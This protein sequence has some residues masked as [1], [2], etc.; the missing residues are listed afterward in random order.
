M[1]SHQSQEDRWGGS[2]R[3]GTRWRFQTSLP[4]ALPHPV[5][6]K[7]KLPPSD[8]DLMVLDLLLWC[9]KRNQYLDNNFSGLLSSGLNSPVYSQNHRIS[10]IG[11]YRS[12]SPPIKWPSGLSS[13]LV[14]RTSF[15][16][17]AVLAILEQLWLLANSSLDW[18]KICLSEIS[19]FGPWGENKSKPSIIWE[20]FKY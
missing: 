18:A 2:A 19:T 8:A 3:S 7:G 15:L 14:T 5:S 11:H 16:P 4:P 10:E 20:P 9:T 6:M 12:P 17:E 1:Y 13:P